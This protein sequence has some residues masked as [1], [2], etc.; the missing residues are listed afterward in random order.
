MS[1]ETNSTWTASSNASW[2]TISPT[3]GGVGK[4]SIKV[5]V[6][7]NDTYDDRNCGV[8][9]KAGQATAVV[10]ISQKQKNALI[11]SPDEFSFESEGGSFEVVIKSNID[12]ILSSDVSWITEVTTKALE[13]RTHVF[14]V[15]ANESSDD[16]EGHV[17]VKSAGKEDRITVLQ[18]AKETLIMG[19]DQ[20]EFGPEGGTLELKVSTNVELDVS[21]DEDSRFWIICLETKSLSEKTLVFNI[22]A[23]DETNDRTGTITVSSGGSLSQTV[24][25]HQFSPELDETVQIADAV[26]KKYCVE[27]FDK[28]GDGEIS[29]REALDVEWIGVQTDNISSLKGIEAFKNLKYLG[30][31]GSDAR[32]G[33]L[34]N[35]DLSMNEELIAVAVHDNKLHSLVLPKGKNL[36]NLIAFGNKIA[37]LDLS[38]CEQL[39]MISIGGNECLS[40]LSL[41]AKADRLTALHLNDNSLSQVDLSAY[42]GLE[43]FLSY[44]NPLRSLDVRNNP[45]LKELRCTDERLEVLFV[46]EGQTIEGVTNNR[47]ED[48][49]HPNT[50]IYTGEP[51]TYQGKPVNIPD[52]VL[53]AWLIE[54]YDKNGDGEIGVQE[55]LEI[56][57]IDMVS[58][59]VETL[60]GIQY[61]PNLK[62]LRVSGNESYN[63]ELR[64]KITEVDLTGNPDL[65]RI[66]LNIQSLQAIDLSKT[67][68]L[69]VLNIWGNHIQHLD[70]SVTPLLEGADIA[71]NGMSDI[72][73]TGLN[74]VGSMYLYGNA[75]ESVDLSSLENAEMLALD[76]CDALREVKFPEN[77]ALKTFYCRNSSIEKLDV[78]TLPKL[79]ELWCSSE[80]TEFLYLREGQQLSH[81]TTDRNEEYIHPN[82]VIITGSARDDHLIVEKTYFELGP[83]GGQLSIPIVADNEVKVT[84]DADW[85]SRPDEK[86]FKTGTLVLDVAAMPRGTSRSAKVKLQAG[87]LEETI[88]VNQTDGDWVPVESVTLNRTSAE[89][90]AGESL[91]LTATVLPENATDKTVTWSSSDTSIASVDQN[92]LVTALTGGNVTI[93]AK[94]GEKTASCEVNI[95]VPVENVSLDR[96][97]VS[98]EEGRTTTLIATVSP[99]DATDKSISWVSSNTS[100]AT[101]SNTGIVTA[102]VE[103]DVVITATAGGKSASC[104]VSVVALVIPVESVSLSQTF[105]ELKEGETL[106]LTAAVLPENATDKTVTWSSSDASIASVDQNGLVTAI[107]IGETTIDAVAGN[108]KA[109]CTIKVERNANS[110]VAFEDESV[111]RLCLLHFD[112]NHDGIITYADLA[113]V[114][115][116]NGVFRESA[117][118]SFPEFQ[119]FIG[120]EGVEQLAFAKSSVEYIVLPPSVSYIGRDAFYQ[121][122]IKSIELPASTK[123]ISEKAFYNCDA[124]TKVSYSG[125][126]LEEI[127]KE[128]FNQCYALQQVIIHGPLSIIGECAFKDCTSLSTF[129]HGD[130]LTQ[131]GIEAFWGAA[132]R[133]FSFP[134]SLTFIGS[135]AFN[136]CKSLDSV[137]MSRCT[138]LTSLSAAVFGGTGVSSVILPPNLTDLGGRALAGTNNLYTLILPSSVDT[139]G[140]APFL[141]SSI[142]HL[143]CQPMVPP[144]RTKYKK[145][146]N[147]WGD[148]PPEGYIV[149][150]PSEAYDAYKAAWGDLP[151]AVYSQLP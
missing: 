148:N 108:E 34:E 151:I 14:T 1:F 2:C 98:L 87:S 134:S 145:T 139:L 76:W 136:S 43:V 150:V 15:T 46:K 88:F 35:E 72:N 105:A 47:S 90:K 80:R 143:Y 60:E 3:S 142:S 81:I 50:I 91:T 61:F 18:L 89:L 44:G 84:V 132:F 119:Y 22:V 10:S 131:I 20:Y 70:L 57:A 141:S 133:E 40:S 110:E 75:F 79:E 31:S 38:S 77:A 125:N 92:G 122:A 71:S 11:L 101:V 121:S 30:A 37:S 124:L 128:A 7:E 42:G 45:A 123:T 62:V 111:K 28:N 63:T 103:G 73:L 135:N 109:S 24:T 21:I 12:Y 67:P 64:G 95:T 59:Q 99:A 32:S 147:P 113:E 17:I 107:K 55:A 127:G 58:V 104:T 94:A 27:N 78:S 13:S 149:F 117:I 5:L 9:I 120:L 137:D 102:L 68:K 138:S 66:E 83:D 54:H 118:V 19:Q 129:E 82:T 48:Y 4:A 52:V 130:K 29:F 114:T 26:F 93:T 144:A 115:S 146:Y 25:V 65:E 97:S 39:E 85:I 23:A 16:R 126:A 116:L 100:V 69:R 140:D 6:S 112:G 49:I 36:Q 74:K 96:T 33:G 86:T 53:K 106:A 41:P 51:S 8:T 56:D